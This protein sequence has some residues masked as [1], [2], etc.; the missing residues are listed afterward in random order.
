MQGT[1]PVWPLFIEFE[2]CMVR[3]VENGGRAFGKEM[4][5]LKN[6]KE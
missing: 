1:I 5:E 6:L 2:P 4:G 3:A